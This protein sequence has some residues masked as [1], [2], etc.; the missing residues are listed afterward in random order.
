MSSYTFAIEVKTIVREP[1]LT[2][3]KWRG[4]IGVSD[5]THAQIYSFCY[6]GDLTIT[7]L[8]ERCIEHPPHVLAR[9]LDA[10]V[11]KRVNHEE[12]QRRRRIKK[13]N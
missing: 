1:R 10:E 2:M 7:Y 13:T 5:G 8:V 4:T 9:A 6:R 11:I 3:G 12:K